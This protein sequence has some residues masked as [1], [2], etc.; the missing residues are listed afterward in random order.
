MVKNYSIGV[1][2]GIQ[3]AHAVLVDVSNG[4]VVSQATKV[5]AHEAERVKQFDDE[6]MDIDYIMKHPKEYIDVLKTIIPVALDQAQVSPEHVIGLSIHMKGCSIIPVDQEGK[7]LCEQTQFL[8]NPYAYVQIWKHRLPQI[9]KWMGS[10][11]DRGVDCFDICNN[12]VS[13]KWMIPQTMKLIDTNPDVYH[14]TEYFLE[15]SEW[16]AMQITGESRDSFPGNGRLTAT[17]APKIGLREEIPVRIINIDSQVAMP[18]YCGIIEEGILANKFNI[19]EG[20]AYTGKEFLWVIKNFV[21]RLYYED[22][23]RHNISLHTLLVKKASEL[24]STRSGLLAI[25]YWKENDETGKKRELATTMVGMTQSTRP[26]EIYRAIIEASA[27]HKKMDLQKLES[28]G[29]EIEQLYAYTEY[30]QC[31]EIIMQIY[32]DILEKEIV[33]VDVCQNI[34]EATNNEKVL[35]HSDATISREIIRPVPERV[36]EYRTIY[37]EY[38]RLYE[39]FT[40]KDS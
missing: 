29:E 9:K 39:Y 37:K 4:K 33:V 34:L 16:I 13:A 8:E 31:N 21:P 1:D 32:A 17:I 22:A 11:Q 6:S 27:F 10:I 26:E 40:H 14:A 25:N 15:A 3:S 5:Y 28:S 24:T 7:L 35:V 18:N 38:Q 36:E 23:K 30:S 12:K 20:P 2:Y 19:K